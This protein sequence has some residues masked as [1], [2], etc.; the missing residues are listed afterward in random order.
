MNDYDLLAVHADSLFTYDMRGR[1]VRS[2][3]PDGHPAPR[4]LLCYSPSGYIIRFN[5]AVPDSVARR[6]SEVVRLAAH[7][8]DLTL[9]PSTKDAVDDILSNHRASTRQESGPIYR[10]PESLADPAEDVIQLI[11]SNVALARDSYPWLLTELDEWRPCFAVVR[12]GAAV[13]ICFSSRIG[14]VANEAG[15]DTLPGYRGRGFASAVT[16]AWARA[17]QAGGRIPLYSTSWD[18]QASQSVARRLGLIMFGAESTW[19]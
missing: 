8:A 14:Q 10:F 18:N 4:V 9:L 2:N 6:I 1:M 5:Q 15:V 7:S 12:D 16:A 19:R 3:E 11:P 13:S 17:V